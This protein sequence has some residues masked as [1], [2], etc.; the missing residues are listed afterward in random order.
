MP[1]APQIQ[2]TFITFQEE[3]PIIHDV[4]QILTKTTPKRK[5]AK[6]KNT[7]C[8]KTASKRTND[9]KHTTE[10]TLGVLFMNMHHAND[11]LHPYQQKDSVTL[12]RLRVSPS[13]VQYLEFSYPP[14][15]T[16]SKNSWLVTKY[17]DALNGGTLRKAQCEYY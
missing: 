17:L 10:K 7:T 14:S 12:G 3:P 11:I 5:Q 6:D 1:S 2:S 13:F 9:L 15:L 16:N 8:K 4:S